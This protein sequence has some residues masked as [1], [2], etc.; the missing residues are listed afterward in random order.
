M[1][2]A[3][4]STHWYGRDGSPCYTIIGKNGNERPTTLRD[5]RTLLLVPSVTTVI[6]CA[7]APGLERWKQ[8]QV[9]YAALTLPKID[10]EPEKDYL[11]RIM[12]DAGERAKQAAE[13]GTIIHAA[14][15]GH[16]EGVPPPEELW[17]HVKGAADAVAEWLKG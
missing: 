16:Y 4:E 17:P 10:G 1:T 8:E 3:A 13:R 2:H 7:A 15:Q 6:K 5:A 14:I 9:L 11:A 12:R